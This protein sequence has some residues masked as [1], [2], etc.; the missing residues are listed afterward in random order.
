MKEFQYLNSKYMTCL[1]I[2]CTYIITC[3]HIIGCTHT[4][5]PWKYSPPLLPESMLQPQVKKDLKKEN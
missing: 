1:L 5:D 2:T 3:T 4:A